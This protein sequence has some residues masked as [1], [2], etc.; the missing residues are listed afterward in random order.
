MA[1]AGQRDYFHGEFS[2]A[3]ASALTEANSRFTLY[4]PGTTTTLTV[5]TGDQVFVTGYAL[6]AAGTTL[7][8]TLYSGADAT[9]DSGERLF[10]A[11]QSNAQ[12]GNFPETEPKVCI[13]STY[14][15]WKTGAAGQV[16]IQISG[17]ISRAAS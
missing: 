5:S 3:D 12:S 16:Y 4:V 8:H 14:P 17:Y 9:V 1:Y 11:R 6:T 7:Q 2:S 15:K 10:E 13:V